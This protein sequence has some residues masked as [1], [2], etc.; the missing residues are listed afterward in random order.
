MA[1]EVVVPPVFR[2]AVSNFLMEQGASGIEEGG[3][4]PEARLKAYFL[5]DGKEKKVLYAV[6]QYLKAVGNLFPRKIRYQVEASPVHE[7]DWGEEWKRFFKPFHVGSRFVVFPPWERVQLKKGQIPIEINP[8]M[9]FGTGSHATTQLCIRALERREK[10]LKKRGFSVLDVGTGSGILAIVSAKLGAREIWASDV[11]ELAIAG[12]RES[13][14]KNGLRGL[15]KIRKGGIGRIGREFDCIVS[16]LEFKGLKR[17]KKP[18]LRHLKGGGL[19]IL[20]GILKGEQEDTI[21]ERYLQTEGLGLIQS[22]H[23]EEWACLIFR[24]KG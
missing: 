13:V 18:F 20:S 12:A 22:D 9:A 4:A 21:K 11:D 1:V 7:Q 2:E 14:A 19:L 15:V 8:G 5:R 6:R 24:E 17:L 3:D 10:G 23:Q 16:N